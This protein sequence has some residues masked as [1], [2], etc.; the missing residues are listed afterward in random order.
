MMK[1]K[2]LTIDHIEKTLQLLEAIITETNHD[3][4]AKKVFDEDVL[5]ETYKENLDR[6]DM[7]M[8]GCFL[9]DDLK[10]FGLFQSVDSFEED[11]EFIFNECILQPNPFESKKSKWLILKNLICFIEDYLKS[12]GNTFAIY[13]SG[14][15]KGYLRFLRS[16][17]YIEQEIVLRKKILVGG[18]A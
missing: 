4:T 13:L 15:H 10:G 6:S 16:T 17:G 8:Y 12:M 2:L 1:C 9:G 14:K 7:I 3:R 5:R 18:K 11:V